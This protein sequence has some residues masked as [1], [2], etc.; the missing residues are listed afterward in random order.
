MGALSGRLKR[1]RSPLIASCDRLLALHGGHTVLGS[2]ASAAVN[3]FVPALA[4]NAVVGYHQADVLIV[5][6]NPL[7]AAMVLRAAI[8]HGREVTLCLRDEN[9]AWPYDL[10]TSSQ[11]L[12][13]VMSSVESLHPSVGLS[14]ATSGPRGLIGACIGNA[15]ASI[16]LLP[17]Q[18]RVTL[19]A[20]QPTRDVFLHASIIPAEP[21]DDPVQSDL[22]REMRSATG[23]C[24]VLEVRRGG[25]PTAIFARKVV[26]VSRVDGFG[27]SRLSDGEGTRS[28][29]WEGA[30]I[31]ALGSAAWDPH[32]GRSA[33]RC[34]VDDVIKAARLFTP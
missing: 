30:D 31:A 4:G 23:E 24:R 5:G 1:S 21:I 9:D 34:M 26:L 11:G 16:T 15:L 6:S 20:R 8:S 14:H 27:V 2:I 10:A 25:R 22:L 29:T 32:D 18:A 28:I 13:L 17:R 19:A 3:E 33:A 12:S 7:L